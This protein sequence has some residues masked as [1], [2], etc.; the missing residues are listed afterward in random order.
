MLYRW[1]VVL[2]WIVA[3]GCR[4]PTAREIQPAFYYWKSVFSLDSTEKSAVKQLGIRKLY[5]KFFDVVWEKESNTAIPAAKVNMADT[6]FRSFDIIP[7]VFI[8]NEVLYYIKDS[9]AIDKLSAN[10]SDLLEQQMKQTAIT[11]GEIQVDCDWTATTKNA[12]FQ[13]LRSVKRQLQQQGYRQFVLSAT[14][15]LYQC[16]Y[17]HKTGVP[18]VDK[19]LLMCY[20]MGNLKNPAVTNS[21]LDTGELEQYISSLD[22]YPLQL[23]VALPL[24]DWKVLF[25]QGEYAGLL[26]ELPT[27]SLLKHPLV[28]VKNNRYTFSRDAVV[29][30]YAFNE[31]DVL[32]DEQSFY[33]DIIKAA[34]L[35]SA[36][37]KNQR[38]AV[39]L[40]HL[41]SV[42]L[43]KY[44]LHELEDMFGR[45]R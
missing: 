36:R 16:R 3:F 31:G 44:P 19:G 40:Y 26:K 18:P 45:F 30:G 4:Q 24:F 25:R 2:L 1:T 42:T 37:L 21:I 20:N 29:N 33:P 32:R 39:V 6:G 34:K 13:L 28:S 38:P 15:R 9:A 23:D 17:L 11:P 41:D 12:Y 10:T 27:D 22:I 8:S 35:V 7:V 43:S 14:I 5:V